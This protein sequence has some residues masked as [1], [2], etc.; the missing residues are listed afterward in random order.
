MTPSC[1]LITEVNNKKHNVLKPRPKHQVLV[2]IYVV[3]VYLCMYA[4]QGFPQNS[5]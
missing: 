1:L 5:Q 3:H 2:H 4:C